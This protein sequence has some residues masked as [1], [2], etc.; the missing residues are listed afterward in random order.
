M[1]PSFVLLAALL[2]AASV[3]AADER[4]RPVKTPITLPLQA[5]APVPRIVVVGH[6]R[7]AAQARLNPTQPVAVAQ[8]KPRRDMNCRG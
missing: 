7:P 3:Q 6:R 4:P 1:K 2:G 5:D 8:A